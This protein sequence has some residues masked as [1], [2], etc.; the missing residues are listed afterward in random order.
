MD[1]VLSGP[2]HCLYQSGCTPRLPHIQCIPTE[3]HSKSAS[4]AMDD[5][6]IIS[7][8]ERVLYNITY[9]SLTIISI[10]YMSHFSSGHMLQRDYKRSQKLAALEASSHDSRFGQVRKN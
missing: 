8:I 9:I 4:A 7:I 1:T 3:H 10:T 2:V 5:D 6:D